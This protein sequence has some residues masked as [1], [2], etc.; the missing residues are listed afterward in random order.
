MR[1]NKAYKGDFRTLARLSI[2]CQ[3]H[4]MR[5]HAAYC[6]VVVDKTQVGTVSIVH[7]TWIYPWQ[8]SF[9]MIDLDIKWLG[10]SSFNDCHIRTIK[11]VCLKHKSTFKSMLEINR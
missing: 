3:L 11:L 1:E 9:G 10:V 7:C 6:V 5:T 8:L 2:G 4:E